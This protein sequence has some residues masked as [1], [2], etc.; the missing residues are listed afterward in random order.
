LDQHNDDLA[1]FAGGMNY[2]CFGFSSGYKR[3]GQT[4]KVSRE[5][6]LVEWHTKLMGF[7]YDSGEG[8]PTIYP[9]TFP[10]RLRAQIYEDDGEG[11][12]GNLIGTSINRIT[13][14][15]INF[16]PQSEVQPVAADFFDVIF[17]F[18]DD[19]DLYP[20]TTY[21][22][23]IEAMGDFDNRFGYLALI[24]DTPGFY[25]DG[26]LYIEESGDGSYWNTPKDG[27]ASSYFIQYGHW[28]PGIS[29]RRDQYRTEEND[30]FETFQ[31]I[32]PT[33]DFGADSD[34]V[35]EKIAVN[36]MPNNRCPL[37]KVKVKLKKGYPDN[38][39]M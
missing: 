24:D 17:Y 22:M 35:P 5:D 15:S 31:E 2:T 11:G 33:A 34:E 27:A 9:G 8:E 36:F 12:L 7:F 19:Y 39:M 16:V 3:I 20:D 29:S 14:D 10:N 25:A 21:W 6:P 38:P 4:F 18:N 1:N 28:S 13:G 26:Q 37:D 23:V 30:T 32:E